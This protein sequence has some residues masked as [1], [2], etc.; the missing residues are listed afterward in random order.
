MEIQ[1]VYNEKKEQYRDW[2]YKCSRKRE[3][4][5]EHPPTKL[6]TPIDRYESSWER[7]GERRGYS[8]LEK[9]K[10]NATISDAK[11]AIRDRFPHSDNFS[12]IGAV[13]RRRISAIDVSYVPHSRC[14]KHFFAHRLMI[15]S[16]LTPGEK[17]NVREILLSF[18]SFSL[19]ISQPRSLSGGMIIA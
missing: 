9:E 18:G 11:Q 2:R 13:Y 14:L 6:A 16:V 15:C 10:A 19:R 4:H 8:K 7:G 17:T 3:L 12:L 5:R 1:H